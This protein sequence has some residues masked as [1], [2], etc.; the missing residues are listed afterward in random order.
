VA[1]RAGHMCTKR[2]HILA[3]HVAV[4]SEKQAASEQ[5]LTPIYA[6]VAC[7]GR[8]ARFSNGKKITCRTYHQEILREPW[9]PAVSAV[10]FIGGL[11]YR[12][13]AF[14]CSPRFISKGTQQCRV[15]SGARIVSC[16]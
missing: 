4:C 1:V 2:S 5:R 9:N 11:P 3:V 16:T 8:T 12:T 13:Q 7:T 15:I 10:M 14:H 6:R